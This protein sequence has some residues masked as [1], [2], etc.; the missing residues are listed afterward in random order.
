MVGLD[1]PV[2]PVEHQFIVME[3]HPKIIERKRKNLPEMASNGVGSFLF[4]LVSTLRAFWAERI[5]IL[6]IF[7]FCVFLDSRLPDSWI[8]SLPDSQ[9]QVR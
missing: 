5:C 8:C 3:Q 1:I 6:T 4:L 7:M 9:A 2:M